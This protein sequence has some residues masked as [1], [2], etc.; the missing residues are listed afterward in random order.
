MPDISKIILPN[1]PTPYD[2]KDSQA[3]TDIENLKGQVSGG[4]HYI[5]VTTTAITD[6]SATNPVSIGGKAVTAVNGDLVIYGNKEFI[7]SVS[8]SKWHEFGD[9]TMLKALAFKDSASTTYTPAGSVSGSFSGASMTSTGKFTPSGSIS[10]GTGTANYTPSGSI[11]GGSVTGGKAAS[12][13]L[14]SLGMS[15]GASDETLTITWSA[16]S[17]TANTPTAVTLPN[18]FTGTGVKLTFSGSQGDVSVSGTTTGSING[19]GFSGT[20]AT[21]TVS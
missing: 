1:V 17:F 5:G 16:G 12:C 6:G 18:T 4:V 2:L 9:R 19:L 13:T 20:Q 10:V 8:D 15:V 21:I 14:P 7:F 11:S 3:R